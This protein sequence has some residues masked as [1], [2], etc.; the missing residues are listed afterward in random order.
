MTD[1]TKFDEYSEDYDSA[2]AE[3]LSVTGEDK[4]FFARGRIAW[5]AKCLSNLKAQPLAAMDFGCGIGTATPYLIELLKVKSLLGIDSSVKCLGVAER[6]WASEQVRFALLDQY[7]PRPEIDFAYT[8][9]V[10]HHIPEA[11]RAAAVNLIYRAL[12][13]GGLFAFWENNPWNPGTRYVMSRCEFDKDAITLTPT[14]ARGLLQSGGFEVLSTDF[15]FIFPK[16]L[17]MLRG[18]EPMVSRLP[19]GGQYQV[20][21]RKPGGEDSAGAE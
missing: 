18:I 11:K 21:C 4:D 3:S 20:L 8:N 2:L 5:A 9:G 6:T 19:L 17:R 10:F 14:S 7:Q 1:E 12:R 15:L 16:A 13:P